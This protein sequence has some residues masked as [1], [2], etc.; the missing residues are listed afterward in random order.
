M[1]KLRFIAPL[2]LF[3][4]LAI[5]FIFSSASAEKEWTFLL[6]LSGDNDLKNEAL[7]TISDAQ[8]TGSTDELNILLLH[9]AEGANDRLY[10]V[11]K[12]SGLSSW[13]GGAGLKNI[14]L[15]SAGI[16]LA[17]D[18]EV[19]MGDANVAKKFIIYAIEK[20]PAKKY[21]IVFWG[22][23]G[24][25]GGFAKDSTPNYD[26][27]TT[28]EISEIFS[29]VRAKLGRNFDFV[30]IDS[31][32]AGSIEN[33]YE[34]SYYVS[35]GVASQKMMVGMPYRS[36]LSFLKSEPYSTPKK[37]T[38]KVVD[39]YNSYRSYSWN[40][41]KINLIAGIELSAVKDSKKKIDKFAEELI[42]SD[43]TAIAELRKNAQRCD[44]DN[45]K[46]LRH[47]AELCKNLTNLR[48]VADVVS[49]FVKDSVLPKPYEHPENYN[50]ISIYFPRESHS[51]YY[52]SHYNDEYTK[53]KFAIDTKW[54]EFL[55]VFML[56]GIELELGVPKANLFKLE[57]RTSI[58]HYYAIK[59][60]EYTG[61]DPFVVMIKTD[62]P[63][64]LEKIQIKMLM[65]MGDFYHADW[66]ETV[67]S[68]QNK[69][70]IFVI[71]Q[72]KMRGSRQFKVILTYKGSIGELL[73]Y[74]IAAYGEFEKI[75]EKNIEQIA[76]SNGARKEGKF[77]K[78]NDEKYYWL[79]LP[80]NKNVNI[81]LRC[82]EANENNTDFDLYVGLE[83]PQGTGLPRI[84]KFDYR[85]FT[86]DANETV[87]MKGS[88]SYSEDTKIFILVRSYEGK[89][90]Y[91]LMIE[92]VC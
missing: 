22:H 80:A 29:P 8:S 47:F 34:L 46:D 36:I 73:P 33:Y 24:G 75:D 26:K 89:G 57:V 88:L 38:E 82:I 58:E 23:A 81:K 6:Y 83:P 70:G 1:V 15:Q 51:G 7:W 27:I 77:K 43:P 44:S 25:G 11:E 71:P 4:F 18:G 13:F 67:N 16:P 72:E 68:N 63:E 20:Y 74:S 35:Y 30:A 91:M 86:I 87:P 40:S 69:N 49:S 50:G 31:C 61:N 84:Y 64:D 55:N 17:Y 9:D 3:L 65:N 59:M 10:Y 79:S 12:K 66:Q 28:P 41:E 19:N 21:G 14:S 62:N 37:L 78:T 76:W 92:E 2:F 32:W 56:G 48:V 90:R 42:N 39:I 53:T 85:G 60:R 45:Y 54:N 5:V 52:Y